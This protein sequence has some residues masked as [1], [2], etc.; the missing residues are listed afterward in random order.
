MRKKYCGKN[1]EYTFN[2]PGKHD[3]EKNLYLLKD[4]NQMSET[5][6]LILKFFNI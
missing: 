3:Y 1:N 5:E 2:K 6:V 4:P